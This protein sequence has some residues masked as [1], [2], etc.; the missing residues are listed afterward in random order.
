MSPFLTTLGGGSVRGFGRSFRRSVAVAAQGQQAYTTAG[1]YTFTVPAGVTSISALCVGGGGGGKGYVGYGATGGALSY[2]NSVS[3][4][5]GQ[6]ITVVVGSGGTGAPAW[7]NTQSGTYTDGGESRADYF[8][9]ARGGGTSTSNVGTSFLGGD[10]GPSYGYGGGGGGGGGGGYSGV[11]GVGGNGDSSATAGTSGAGG[12]GGGG[13]G[14]AFQD[15]INSYDPVTGDGSKYQFGGGGGGGVGLLGSGSNGAG[16]AAGVSNSPGNIFGRGGGAGSS[17][18]A[19]ADGSNLFATNL[20]GGA[21]GAYGGGG[22]NGGHKYDETAFVP[23]SEYQ[24]A[25]GNGAVG[26]VRIIWG[27]GRSYPSNAANV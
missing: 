18:T 15:D 19:G 24:G 14:G 4:T 26:A 22:G 9:V 6:N 16:G 25:G 7:T 3:V 12:A 17:G 8:C 20:Y 10:G 13:G 5:P 11:G 23:T 27:A 1:T 2:I 21:G